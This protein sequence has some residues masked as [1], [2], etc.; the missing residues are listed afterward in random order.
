MNKKYFKYTNTLFVITPIALITVLVGFMCNYSFSEDLSFKFLKAWGVI[1]PV[2]YSTA[3][4]IIPNARKLAQ[5][6][7]SK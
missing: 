5:K 1:I 6:T 4:I 3:F 7:T 2:A